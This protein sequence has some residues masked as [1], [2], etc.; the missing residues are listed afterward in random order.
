VVSVTGRRIREECVLSDYIR[1]KGQLKK[2]DRPLIRLVCLCCIEKNVQIAVEQMLEQME[3]GTA[4][5]SSFRGS[6]SC[7]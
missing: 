3:D 1:F 4:L 2:A 7:C 6:G 5:I